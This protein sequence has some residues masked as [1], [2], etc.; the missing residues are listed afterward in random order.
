M[1]TAIVLVFDNSCYQNWWI[2]AIKRKK[3]A[4]FEAN[5]DWEGRARFKVCNHFA[6]PDTLLDHEAKR[7]VGKHWLPHTVELCHHFGIKIERNYKG[8]LL[9]KLSPGVHVWCMSCYRIRTEHSRVM[10][11]YESKQSKTSHACS[12]HH[13]RMNRKGLQQH[14]T[15]LKLFSIAQT[16][17]KQDSRLCSDFLCRQILK[18]NTSIGACHI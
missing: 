7:Q 16:T 18:L 6:I 5:S 13:R 9:E 12:K 15:K 14:R 1:R 10:P 17:H 11:R 4:R 2:F 3:V 8:D